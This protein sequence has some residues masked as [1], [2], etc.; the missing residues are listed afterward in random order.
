[1]KVRACGTRLGSGPSPS[2]EGRSAT[3][4]ALISGI[5]TRHSGETSVDCKPA[6]T[7][8][9]EANAPECGLGQI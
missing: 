5:T 9:E 8:R 2:A 7:R 4:E 6:A 3:A 1:M